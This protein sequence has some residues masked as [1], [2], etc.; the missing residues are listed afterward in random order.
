[1]RHDGLYTTYLGKEYRVTK[2]I[3]SYALVSED[4][5]D[6][7]N[8]FYDIGDGFFKRDIPRSELGECFKVRNFATCEGHE[9]M[10]SGPDDNGLVWLDTRDLSFAEKYEHFLYDNGLYRV[11]VPM[12]KCTFRE[13]IIPYSL[14]K[15]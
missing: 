8:N 11:G 12:E 9:S 4:I 14:P 6:L 15:E 3:D 13:Q 2:K 5:S 7:E 10:F 1:M